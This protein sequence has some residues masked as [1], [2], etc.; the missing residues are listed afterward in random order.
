MLAPFRFQARERELGKRAA[1]EGRRIGDDEL[2]DSD[3]RTDVA[4]VSCA[5]PSGCLSSLRT[6]ENP[7]AT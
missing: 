5:G 4:V 3:A 1:A 7:G 6:G 2:R